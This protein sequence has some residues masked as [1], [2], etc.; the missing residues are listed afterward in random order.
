MPANDSTLC[1]QGS[2]SPE[3]IT[4]R[5]TA[6]PVQEGIYQ[7]WGGW[8]TVAITL[9]VDVDAGDASTAVRILLPYQMDI[10]ASGSN[11][12]ASVLTDPEWLTTNGRIT[13]AV[14]KNVGGTTVVEFQE[15]EQGKAL[16]INYGVL[17]N[18]TL[19]FTITYPT[20]GIFNY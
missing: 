20:D 16:A 13:R 1:E 8:A 9:D 15:I 3:I 14:V 5:P 12:F 17:A 7:K 2:F 18:K 4:A 6:Y 11:L 10:A 19:R